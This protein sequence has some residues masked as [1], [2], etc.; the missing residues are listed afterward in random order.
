MTLKVMTES[1]LRKLIRS[2]LINEASLSTNKLFSGG[3]GG[4]GSTI[5]IGSGGAGGFN[6]HLQS[7]HIK[8]HKGGETKMVMP[9]PFYKGVNYAEKV[10]S[11]PQE[12]RTDVGNVTDSATGKVSKRGNRSHKGYDFGLPTGTPVLAMADG[13]VTAVNTNP[14]ANAGGIY[15][16]ITHKG[17]GLRSGS[18]HMSQVF[19]KKGDSVKKGQIVGMSGN[20]GKSTGPHLHFGLRRIGEKSNSFDKRFYDSIFAKCSVVNLDATQ[21]EVAKHSENKKAGMSAKGNYSISY[22][23]KVKIENENYHKVKH[24]VGT[25][26]KQT[27]YFVK[28]GSDGGEIYKRLKKGKPKIGST[29]VKSKDTK[30]HPEIISAIKKNVSK[31]K[32]KDSSEEEEGYTAGDIAVGLAAAPLVPGYVAAS[33][34]L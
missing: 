29:I 33:A 14:G 6:Q 22:L 27:G 8:Y 3:S 13:T 20:T 26:G 15:I 7:T 32:K 23:G 19:F 31:S 11:P 24:Q 10:T 34:V 21:E 28:V 18:M 12:T 9:T 16:I 1:A 2:K 5:D 17:V 25:T 30:F 4:V